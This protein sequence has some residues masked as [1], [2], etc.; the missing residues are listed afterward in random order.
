MQV[1]GAA[2]QPRSNLTG[3]ER[4]E[5]FSEIRLFLEASLASGSVSLASGVPDLKAAL[6]VLRQ[7]LVSSLGQAERLEKPGRAGERCAAR[8]DGDS[9]GFRRRCSGCAACGI[10]ACP[11][12][13]SGIDCAG[14]PAA[15]D[16]RAAGRW[17]CG[18]G[19][20][21]PDRAA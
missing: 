17:T 7:T 15:A 16:G 5:C 9:R 20:H 1:A 19:L 21:R 6:I 14:D 4:P 12:A 18:I 10:D 2:D 11:I 13:V 8:L 3:N